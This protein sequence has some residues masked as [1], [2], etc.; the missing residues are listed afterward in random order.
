MPS[1]SS[2]STASKLPTTVSATRQAT[3]SS[4]RSRPDYALRRGPAY[5]FTL[6]EESIEAEGCNVFF[7]SAVQTGAGSYRTVGTSRAVALAAT[8][9]SLEQARARVIASAAAV[10]VLESRSD[11]GE[12]SYLDGLSRLVAGP[13]CAAGPSLLS[14]A[15]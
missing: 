11:I 12:A 15:V 6:P 1:C 10:S 2:T 7:S 3:S 8:A 9:P 5:D 13:S 14:K 4:S